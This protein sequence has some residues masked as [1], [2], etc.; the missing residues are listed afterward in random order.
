MPNL[1]DYKP[2]LSIEITEEQR[3]KLDRLLGTYGIKRTIISIVLDDLLDLIDNYG[4]VIIG[5]ILEKS[6]KPHE[7]L[8]ILNKAS[9]IGKSL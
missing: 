1:T 9:K 8:P 5:I 3:N 2:R 4:Q 6:T 7:I